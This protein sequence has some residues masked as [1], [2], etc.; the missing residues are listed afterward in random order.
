[1][2]DI[3]RIAGVVVLYNSPID[4]LDNIQSY[5][6]QIEILYIVTN[7]NNEPIEQIINSFQTIN[8][9]III[10]K[11]NIGIASAL[12]QAIELAI[13]DGF[14]FLLMMDQDSKVSDSLVTA[15][16]NEF[17]NDE[18]IGIL[19]PFVV[20]ERN[21]KIPHNSNREPIQVAMTSGSMIRLSI[22]KK[23]GKLLD[24]FF[25]DYVDQEISLRMKSN[26]FKIYQLNNVFVF[27]KLGNIVEKKMFGKKI[28]PMNY[29]PI[30]LYYKTRNRFYVYKMYKGIFSDFIKEDRLNF[31]KEIIKI[32]LFE[33]KRLKKLYMI[34]KGFYHYKIGILGKLGDYSL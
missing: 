10:N 32:I 1:M 22:I 11:N 3:K 28:F 2:N 26:G 7:S 4:L 15:M 17:N 27:H 13:L 9:K 33:K 12:N 8:I 31:F 20:H 6:N 34:L 5:I 21:P 19:A 30:R 23:I 18:L 14:D 16:T 24:D 25:I 29:K